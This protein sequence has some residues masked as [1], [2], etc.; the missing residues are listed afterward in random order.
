MQMRVQTVCK[1]SGGGERR[2]I[3]Y[4]AGKDM[5]L[6]KAS[7]KKLLYLQYFVMAVLAE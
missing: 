1:P 5:G 6:R 4:E 3:E 2:E 7:F